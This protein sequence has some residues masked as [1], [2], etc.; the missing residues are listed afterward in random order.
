MVSL[1]HR[2][3]VVTGAGTGI[4]AAIGEAL[5]GEGVRVTALGR[6][7]DV[8]ER[9]AVRFPDRVDA[10]RADVTDED[11][12]RR[13]FDRAVEERGPVSIVIANAGAAASAPFPRHD[14]AVWSE[15]IGVNLTGCYLTFRH[16]LA[17]M[18]GGARWG[19]LIAVASTAGL[20]GYPYVAGYCAAKHGV[21][22]LVRALA[23]ELAKA[24]ITVNA[25][26]PG[27]TESPLLERSVRNIVRRSTM[28][29]EDAREALASDSPLGRF[30]RPEEIARAVL[31]LCGP[32]SDAVTGQSI[33]VSGG[34]TW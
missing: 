28:S 31:W 33:S 5:A 4:G 8:L 23:V 26:C 21:I 7:L 19:R 13:A 3:A 20:K 29:A 25:V 11:S 27:F 16:G 34:A 18:D 14:A 10:I 1:E 22:G 6:R 9:L 24:G 32:G 2:H 12:L 30:V 17:A 15:M